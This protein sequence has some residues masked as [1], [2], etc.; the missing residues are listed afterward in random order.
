MKHLGLGGLSPTQ[1]GVL[2]VSVAAVLLA[3]TG[4][5]LVRLRPARRDPVL[6][7]YDR[8]CRKLARAGTERA[9]HE[10]PRDYLNRAA[11]ELPQAAAQLRTIGRLY[12]QLRYGRRAPREA[13]RQL[14][15]A[16]RGLRVAGRRPVSAS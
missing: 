2:A 11:A 13:V 9:P 15:R 1:L 12:E 7:A 8:L 16:V 10:G 4:L 5:W 3:A 14:Q 6:A